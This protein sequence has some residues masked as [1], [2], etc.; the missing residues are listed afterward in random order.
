MLGLIFGGIDY[1]PKTITLVC[2]MIAMCLSTTRVRLNEAFKLSNKWKQILLI[3]FLNFV[4]LTGLILI[5]GLVFDFST[6]IWA[7]IVMMA[8]VPSAVAV[9]PYNDILKG[10]NDLGVSATAL[11]YLASL[12]ITPFIVIMII[13]TNVNVW[14]LVEALVIL[15]I[16]PLI[17]SRG[18]RLVKTDE[19]LGVY[20][21]VLVNAAFAVLIFTVVGVNRAVFFQNIHLVLSLIIL[22]TMRT[23]VIGT[24]VLNLAR[25]FNVNRKRIVTYT[26]FASYKNLGLAIVLAFAVFGPIATIPATIAMPFEILA[27]VYFKK[28]L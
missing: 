23:F 13:G 20:K 28:I 7:G 17:I 10:D 11:V 1:H 26:M 6:M 15:I 5:L 3:F 21:P 12:F 2:L 18:L 9:I 4:L 8:A 27:F 14:E 19:K 16:L 22:S 24:L 25:N